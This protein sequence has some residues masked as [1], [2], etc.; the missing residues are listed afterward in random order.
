MYALCVG[1]RG[2]E[3]VLRAWR[4]VECT[5]IVRFESGCWVFGTDGC[6]GEGV[7]GQLYCGQRAVQCDLTCRFPR[8][9][10]TWRLRL[11]PLNQFHES[12]AS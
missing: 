3:H 9:N 2:W 12:F 5:M 8:S 6:P 1:S 11:E 10:C 4:G 7:S